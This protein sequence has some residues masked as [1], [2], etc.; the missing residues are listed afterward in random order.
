L[1][2]KVVHPRSLE[3]MEM[4]PMIFDF[5]R[6]NKVSLLNCLQRQSVI[7]WRE[8]EERTHFKAAM[9]QGF[10]EIEY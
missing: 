8:K 4:V 6:N 3:D 7:Q 10:V 1:L 9:H 2:Q 5:N